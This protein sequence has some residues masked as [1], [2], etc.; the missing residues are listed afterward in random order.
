MK[1][2]WKIVALVYFFLIIASGIFAQTVA[3]LVSEYGK[4]ASGSFKIQNNT[5]QP[6]AV[7][8]EAYSFSLDKDGQHFRKLDDTVH[9][10]LSQSSARLSPME[11]HEF[12]YKVTCAAMPCMVSFQT[13]MVVGHTTDGLQVR[14]ILPHAVYL[15]EKQKN[16]R[17]DVLTDAGLWK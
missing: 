16:C 12:N 8:V 17:Q 14:L 10:T 11:I 3:P 15:C 1:I 6:V 9:V 4:K 13:G 5:L 2:K 7:T